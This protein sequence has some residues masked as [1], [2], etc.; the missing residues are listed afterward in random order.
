MLSF[1][2]STMNDL[3]S[4]LHIWSS[5]EFGLVETADAYCGSSSI[6]P[7]KKNPYALET[8]KKAAGTSTTWAAA[9]LGCFRAE[10]TGD[11][12]PREV[13]QMDQALDVTETTLDYMAG[14]LDTLIVHKDRMR[15]MAAGN[16][17]TASNLADDIVRK[18]GLSYRQTHHVVARL[19]RIAI[20][21]NI[22]P[23]L[24]TTD[25][26]DRA[27]ME[28]IGKPLRLNTQE[29]RD[30]LDPEAFVET[31]VTTGSPNAGEVK[32]MIRESRARLGAEKEV[33][34]SSETVHRERLRQAGACN[35]ANNL[36]ALEETPVLHN[37]QH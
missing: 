34:R 2:M 4:D 6:F 22:S 10:G 20:E 19:V 3:A 31:R 28:T 9:A 11:I 8:I 35:G 14:V 15:E 29:V 17:S 23:S 18:R 5:Y 36:M 26:V 25:I 30:A 33:G 27:A 21:E 7:Q 1:I 24:A 13:S 12:A 37:L 16:W 32:R